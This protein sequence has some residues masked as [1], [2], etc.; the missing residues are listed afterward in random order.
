[1]R[2]CLMIE[3]QEGVSWNEWVS[4]ARAAES[5]GL[6]GLFRSDHYSSL[7]AAP[8]AA[9]DAWSTITGLAPLTKRIRL[10]T[11]VSPVTFRH[12]SVLARMVASAD[13][14]SGGR[15]EVG[16]GCGWNQHEHEQNGLDFPELRARF[17]LL[18]EHLEILVRSWS[19]EPFSYQSAHYDLRNQLAL[20]KPLQLPYP[21]ITLGGQGKPRALELAARFASEYNTIARSAEECRER[22]RALDAACSRAQRD[23]ASL[24]L[25]IMAIAALGISKADADARFRRTLDRMP[26]TRDRLS[27]GLGTLVG[28]V[29]EIASRLQDF[30]RAGVTR[31]YLN[32]VDRDD[33][34]GVDL[35]GELARAVA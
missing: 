9:L 21:P 4:L 10:G 14:I 16:L 12:P 26:N 31:A 2:V 27:T 35:M 8:G 25:S 15:V 11:L 34:Q 13:H 17:D 23:P 29:E 28:T 33:P 30:K 1:M 22:R 32:H 6:D 7:H 18:A 3:G 20:P 24:K 19:G 5:A